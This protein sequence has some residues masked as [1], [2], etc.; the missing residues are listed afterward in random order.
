[1][2]VSKWKANVYVWQ[3]CSNLLLLDVSSHQWEDPGRAA[4]K[5]ILN[6][7]LVE[8]CPLF[9]QRP[10][11]ACL[12]RLGYFQ[13]GWNKRSGHL[14][15]KSKRRKSWQSTDWVTC[16]LC[17]NS[18]G[19]QFWSS[20][21]KQKGNEN[22]RDNWCYIMIHDPAFLPVYAAK[23]HDCMPLSTRRGEA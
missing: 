11:S 12:S 9:W 6:R 17:C 23:H 19:S 4:S 18:C 8:V 21:K 7:A 15:W 3:T 2:W 20:R 22:K 14:I 10:V 5:E 16:N 1:M 13:L